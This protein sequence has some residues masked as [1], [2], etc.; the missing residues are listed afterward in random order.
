MNKMMDWRND[1]E[2]AVEAFVTVT[3]LDSAFKGEL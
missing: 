3:E 2:S 1:M